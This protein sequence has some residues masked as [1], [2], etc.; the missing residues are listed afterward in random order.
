MAGPTGAAPRWRHGAAA[1]ARVEQE[2]VAA[3]GVPD[4]VVVAG[5]EHIVAGGAGVHERRAVRAGGRRDGRDLAV[6]VLI[7]LLQGAGALRD[8][9]VGAVKEHAATFVGDDALG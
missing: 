2:V 4:D 3:V 5:E 8:E 6:V 1:D 9:G 7:D